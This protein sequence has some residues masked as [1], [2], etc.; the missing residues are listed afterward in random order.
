MNWDRP[1]IRLILILLMILSPVTVAAAKRGTKTSSPKRKV[2]KERVAK[3]NELLTPSL[4][5]SSYDYDYG[6]W[7]DE[8]G[9]TANDSAHWYEWDSR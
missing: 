4:P 6:P 1:T 9:S 8:G 7:L 3:C 5:R 2:Q